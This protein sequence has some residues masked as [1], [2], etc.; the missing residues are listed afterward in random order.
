[1]YL[2]VWEEPEGPRCH[3]TTDTEMADR[4]ARAGADVSVVSTSVEVETVDA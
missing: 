2:I 4:N 1:M 3:L